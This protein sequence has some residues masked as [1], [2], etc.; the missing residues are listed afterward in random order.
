M[1]GTL[2]RATVTPTLT[3]GPVAAP[4]D[5]REQY[6][7]ALR[8]SMVVHASFN[9]AVAGIDDV[10]S[11]DYQRENAKVERAMHRRIEL[12]KQTGMR[13]IE[14]VLPFITERRKQYLARAQGLA[15]W[16]AAEV[17]R[18]MSKDRGVADISMVPKE[19]G[20]FSDEEVDA[21]E[22]AIAPLLQ[23]MGFE[24]P[25][26]NKVP[27]PGTIRWGGYAFELQYP[28]GMMDAQ[29]QPGEHGLQG[30]L[31]SALAVYGV[32]GRVTDYARPLAR[33][34]EAWRQA[35]TDIEVQRLIDMLAAALG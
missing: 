28:T 6:D 19:T 27:D 30:K 34:D 18:R 35:C 24:V 9:A 22:R 31:I 14:D 29:P 32:T 7:A 11:E 21:W 3:S 25:V 33:Y 5:L 2:Q 15:E 8:E 16:H 17:D 12:L 1:I 4:D 23:E 26:Y 10:E 13:T 20:T